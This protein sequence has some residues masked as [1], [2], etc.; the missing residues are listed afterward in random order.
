[1]CASQSPT[2]TIFP[3]M[4]TGRPS[5]AH[6]SL[7][8]QKDLGMKVD[9]NKDELKDWHRQSKGLKDEIRDK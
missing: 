1:M 9:P 3:M 4:D 7:A 2:K 5:M 8:K 6:S